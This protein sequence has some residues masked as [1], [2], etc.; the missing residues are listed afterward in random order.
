M[1]RVVEFTE[2]KTVNIISEDISGLKMWLGGQNRLS[3]MN[4]S[5]EP[6]PDWKQYDVQV[7][8][9]T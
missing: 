9:E 8:L 2:A 3:E 1:Y 7:H 5:K 4:A 6:G